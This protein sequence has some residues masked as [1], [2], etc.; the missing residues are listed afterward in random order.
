MNEL[1]G[2]ISI[3]MGYGDFFFFVVV[4]SSLDNTDKLRGYGCL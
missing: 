4:I 2:R 3:A 1:P